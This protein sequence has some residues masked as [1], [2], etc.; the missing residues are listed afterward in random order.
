MLV[1]QAAK[2]ELLAKYY[3]YSN[4]S[5]HTM[6]YHKHLMC[7]Q[8]LVALESQHLYNQTYRAQPS[9]GQFSF[10]RVLHASP[11][12]P[13]VD[14]YVNGE[15]A[16]SELAFKEYTDYLQIPPGQYTIEVFPAGDT[17]NRVLREIVSV[18]RNTYYTVAAINTLD[19]IELSAFVDKIYVSPN[20]TKVRFIHLSPD[21]PNVDIAVKGGKVIF[22]NVP[23][24]KAT[25][26]LELAPGT[27]DLEVRVAGTSNVVLTIPRVPLQAGKTYTAV[28]VGLAK[29]MP[30][31]DAIFLMP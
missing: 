12:A 27:V 24:K 10:V 2:Y 22:S 19:N 7:V 20:K 15:K 25:D 30:R 18:T 14:I 21:A 9:A 26:Y 5:L 8:Q 4:P 6:Y 31:L 13:A 28:A 29:G 16:V 3:M 1:L 23:F 17:T 11:D